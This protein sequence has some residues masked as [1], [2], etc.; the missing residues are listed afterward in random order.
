MP[1]I[2][3]VLSAYPIVR[4]R[5]ARNEGRPGRAG[6]ERR[7]SANAARFPRLGALSESAFGGSVRSDVRGKEAYVTEDALRQRGRRLGIGRRVEGTGNG[8]DGEDKK[9]QRV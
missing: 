1:L 5:S 4:R 9:D 2:F 6:G 3:S 8:H 7:A